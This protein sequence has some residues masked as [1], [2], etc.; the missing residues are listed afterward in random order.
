[1]EPM[2]ACA[3]AG[4]V[5][6]PLNSRLT[7]RELVFMLE[8]S[9]AQAQLADDASWELARAVRDAAREGRPLSWPRRTMSPTVRARG[10]GQHP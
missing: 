4:L 10:F 8:D 1:M 7:P 5:F 2:F 3:H 6:T 9:G